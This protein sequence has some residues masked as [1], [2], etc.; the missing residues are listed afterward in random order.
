MD[1]G[2]E[3]KLRK[4][5]GKSF[6]SN[7]CWGFYRGREAGQ[8]LSSRGPF[9]YNLKVSPVALCVRHVLVYFF[10]LERQGRMNEGAGSDQ[11]SVAS[12]GRVACRRMSVA[13]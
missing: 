5:T 12:E 13:V 8:F 1:Q 3:E 6:F 11:L 10:E 9:L 2:F 7:S 4:W